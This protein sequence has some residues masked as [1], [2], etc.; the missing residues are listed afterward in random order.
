MG[1]GNLEKNGLNFLLIQ[2]DGNSEPQSSWLK[3]RNLTFPVNQFYGSCNF[4]SLI[5]ETNI[6]IKVDM[7]SVMFLQ[8]YVLL[9][10]KH[11]QTWKKWRVCVCVCIYIYIYIYIYKTLLIHHLAHRHDDFL[12]ESNNS[13]TPLG[14]EAHRSGAVHILWE[15]K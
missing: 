14:S 2:R 8:T 4:L 13:T 15:W 7:N 11:G 5:M 12:P 6:T 9:F 1:E 10:I 3:E